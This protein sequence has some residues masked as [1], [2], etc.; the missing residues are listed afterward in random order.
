MAGRVLFA[1]GTDND[2][3]PTCMGDTS[4]CAPGGQCEGWPQAE[5]APPDGVFTLCRSTPECARLDR[6]L[7]AASRARGYREPVE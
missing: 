4:T 1:C 5:S 6:H 2:G 3:Y 7:G